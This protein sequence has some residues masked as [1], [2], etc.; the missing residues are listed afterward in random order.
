L[1]QPLGKRR[2]FLLQQSCYFLLRHVVAARDVQ[3][4]RRRSAAGFYGEWRSKFG[5][6]AWDLLQKYA[7]ELG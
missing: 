2:R 7:G 6:D 4:K 3:T 5:K 1:P